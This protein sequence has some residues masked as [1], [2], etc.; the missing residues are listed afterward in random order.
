MN[1]FAGLSFKLQTQR[2]Y[3]AVYQDSLA[4]NIHALEARSIHQSLWDK[5]AANTE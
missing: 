1:H 2:K 5:E 4:L 3:R